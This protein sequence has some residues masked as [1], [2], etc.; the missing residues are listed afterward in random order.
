MSN[1]EGFRM[2]RYLQTQE[3]TRGYVH[4]IKVFFFLRKKTFNGSM[5]GELIKLKGK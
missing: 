1:E 2:R 4:N 5:T 3:N